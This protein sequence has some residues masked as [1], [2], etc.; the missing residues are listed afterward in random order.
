V[1]SSDLAY[2]IE[3]AEPY[4]EYNKKIY[5]SLPFSNEKKL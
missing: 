4:N 5:L 3:G 1:C 2:V